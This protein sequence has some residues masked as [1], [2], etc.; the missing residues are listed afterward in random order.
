MDA[1]LRIL[2]LLVVVVAAIII[3]KLVFG[4]ITSVF[5]GVLT[6]ITIIVLAYIGYKKYKSK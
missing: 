4:L 3:V 5:G 1:V 2:G 6:T